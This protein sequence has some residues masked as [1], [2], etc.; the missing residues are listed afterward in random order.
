MELEVSQSKVIVEPEVIGETRPADPLIFSYL[1]IG[2][3]EITV[4]GV[5][6]NTQE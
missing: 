4:T 5:T 2:W 3:F 1:Q 6:G